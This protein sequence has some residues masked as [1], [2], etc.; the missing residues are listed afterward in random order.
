MQTTQNLIE[1]PPTVTLKDQNILES[2]IEQLIE[3]NPSV[4]PLDSKGNIVF[5]EKQKYQGRKNS[6]L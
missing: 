3:R 6:G 1:I 4:L 5:V 2:I